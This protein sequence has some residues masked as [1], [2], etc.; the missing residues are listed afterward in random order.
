MMNVEEAWKYSTGKGVVVG[1]IDSGV[2]AT[3]QD[4]G[5]DTPVFLEAGM[6]RAIV[7]KI[8]SNVY[9]CIQQEKHPKVLP[10]W[11]FVDDSEFTF[12][13][14]RHGTAMAG[15]IAADRD[16]IGIVGVAPDCKIRP[17]VILD[18]HG[19]GNQDTLALAIDRAVADGCDVINMSLAWWNPN[20][21]VQ[22][23]VNTA[24]AA[25]VILIA[26]TGN[27]DMER[28]MYPAAYDGVIAVG[29]CD[30]NDNRWMHSEGRGSNYGK[31]L[32]CVC[33][34]GEHLTTQRLRSRYTSVD[35]TSVAA[36]NMSGVAALVK[37]ACGDL[38]T[39]K[40]K[41]L[42]GKALWS[43]R[44]GITFTGWGVPDAGMIV[45]AVMPERPQPKPKINKEHLLGLIHQANFARGKLS[46]LSHEVEEL[47]KLVD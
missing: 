13:F 7:K 42:V 15:I 16:D 39:H 34:G 37:G 21:A 26:A 5:W 33:P 8:T 40:L 29:A 3:H 4:L 22:E 24:V 9:S 12:D 19:N 44:T 1:L 45:K 25:G 2:D 47:I 46:I 30:R 17:Y 43:D 6:S 18:G 31:E 28:I 14:Y 38:D 36:A 10:G 27:N 20:K 23:A 11:D 41:A 35:A 32:F